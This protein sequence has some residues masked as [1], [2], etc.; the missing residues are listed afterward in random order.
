MKIELQTQRLIYHGIVIEVNFPRSAVALTQGIVE[1][2]SDPSTIN[3]DKYGD[4]WLFE[5][6]GSSDELMSAA[7]YVQ[8]LE[9]VWEVTQRTIKGQ[10]N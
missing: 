1:L 2:L 10:L 7:D 4:G 3:V 8:H 5:I 9:S 6:E